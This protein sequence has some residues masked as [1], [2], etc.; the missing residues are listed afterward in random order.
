MEKIDPS[1]RSKLASAPEQTVGLIV[2]TVGDPTPH[3]ERLTEL[4][5]E[6]G[7]QFRLL[8]GVSVTGRARAALSLVNEVWILKIEEDLPITTT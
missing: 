7:R 4:G 3:L 2:R 8:P 5:L 1:L 6:V